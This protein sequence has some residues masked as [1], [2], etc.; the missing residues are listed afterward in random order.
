MVDRWHALRLV[1]TAGTRAVF[2]SAGSLGAVSV[3]ADG[4]KVFFATK[5]LGQA[6]DEG[7]DLWLYDVTTGH[8]RQVATVIEKKKA[9]EAYPKWLKDQQLDWAHYNQGYTNRILNGAPHE[10]VEAYRRSSPI[11]Y[12]KGLRDAL[13]IQHGLVDDNVQIKSNGRCCC[14][15]RRILGNGRLRE[16]SPPEPGRRRRFCGEAP[17]SGVTRGRQETMSNRSRIP[18][19]VLAA[20]A[21]IRQAQ[22]L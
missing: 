17:E 6:S 16:R 19:L 12:A 14:R 7:S 22:L 13:Q 1:A 21:G 15:D 10:D 4:G 11:Y 18:I 3:S 9:D 8:S 5:G 2:T 20:P